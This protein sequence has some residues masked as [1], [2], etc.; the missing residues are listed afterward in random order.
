[1]S[2]RSH[3]QLPGMKSGQVS[4]FL[5]CTLCSIYL[6]VKR[7]LHGSLTALRLHSRHFC[8]DWWLRNHITVLTIRLVHYFNHFVCA[9]IGTRNTYKCSLSCVSAQVINFLKRY[10]FLAIN[11]KFNAKN[12]YFLNVN[13]SKYYWVI[14]M[15]SM[16]LVTE[17]LTTDSFFVL[18][19]P[20]H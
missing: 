13:D 1:M 14:C 8:Y 19:Q 16:S 17:Q 10:I 9:W 11:E 3:N 7:C 4:F 6:E 5:H 20:R 2:V 18:L 15:W 12:T